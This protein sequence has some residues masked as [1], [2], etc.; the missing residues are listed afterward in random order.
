MA[1]TQQ[2]QSITQK[3][4]GAVKSTIVPGESELAKWKRTF[5]SFA[6]V[7]IDGKK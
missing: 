4:T 1:Q 7:E 5:E 6:K 2:P 3:V